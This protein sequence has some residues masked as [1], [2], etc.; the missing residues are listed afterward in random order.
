M[1]TLNRIPVSS[2]ASVA[3]FRRIL[4][5]GPLGR[6]DV[7]RATGLSQSA[8]TKAVNPLIEAGFVV[9][10][11]PDDRGELGVGRPVNP[12][13]VAHGRAHII[14]VK[15][16]GTTT[17]GVLTDLSGVQIA[18]A[19]ARNRAHDVREIIDSIAEVVDQIRE[20][21]PGPA[22]DG[23]GVAISGDV[24]RTA[25]IIRD[26]PLLG[27]TDVPLRHLLETRLALPVTVEN[28]VRALTIAEHLFGAGRDARSF[29]VVTIGEGIG[30]GL[31]VNGR[32]VDGAY[33][34]SGEIGHLPLAPRD[35]VCS[36]GRHGCVETVASTRA[37]VD[38]VRTATGMP[39]LEAADV[40]RLAHEN[41][42]PS[43]EAFEAAGEVIGAALAAL[44]NII[45]PERVII[46]GEG[47]LE[48]ELYADRLKSTI[49]EHAF[50]AAAKAEL[51]LTKHTFFDWAL[52][53]AVCV[54]E[55][56]A[57]GSI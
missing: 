43:I 55:E 23:L 39:D 10:T 17:Y 47:A 53:A 49:A 24:D 13:A 34:V 31:F 30:C 41:H 18:F 4:T 45:G 40:I 19:T 56:I 48:Y 11:I 16:T 44:I 26:S 22:V 29:A 50:G 57:A 54:I 51:T 9:E 28:D 15:V 36:C 2:P 32:I 35:L 6:I 5:H 33:G 27:W 21:N 46:A 52:G 42:L 7:A 8:V 3:V 1:N 20:T 12:L 37:I 25:G 14:G 38:R